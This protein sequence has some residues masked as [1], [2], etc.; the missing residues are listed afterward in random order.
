MFDYEINLKYIVWFDYTSEHNY[1][2]GIVNLLENKGYIVVVDVGL[3][4]PFCTHIDDVY[5]IITIKDIQ[6]YLDCNGWI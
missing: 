2:T 5:E 6:E 4:S 3:E 1:N